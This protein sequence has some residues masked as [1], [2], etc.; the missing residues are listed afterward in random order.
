MNELAALLLQ[1]NDTQLDAS[2]K[3][4]IEKWSDPPTSL[5]VLEVLDHC[6]FAALASGFVVSVLQALYDGCLQ[7]EGRAHSDNEPL[8]TW[9]TL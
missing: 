3:P 4:L 7:R 6:I 8:A 2:M 5:Q 9:R 1:A